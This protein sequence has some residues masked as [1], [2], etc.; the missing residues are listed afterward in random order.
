MHQKRR[1]SPPGGR[2]P[3]QAGR[4]NGRG[5]WLLVALVGVAVAGG[6]GAWPYLRRAA[7]PGTASPQALRP[8]PWPELSRLDPDDQAQFGDQRTT[9]EGLQQSDPPDPAALAAAFGRLGQLGLAYGFLDAAE[10]ALANASVLSPDDPRW[11]YYLGYLYLQR[12]RAAEA[13]SLLERTVAR[14]PYDVPAMVHLGE[15]F[16]DLKRVDD[17]KRVLNR[18]VQ[19]DPAAASARFVLG[20]IAFEEKDLAAAIRHWEAVLTLQPRATIVHRKLAEAYHRL[21]EEDRSRAHLA[22]RG[23][24]PVRLADPRIAEVTALRRAASALI[25]QGDGLMKSGHFQDAEAVFRRAVER[26]P[27]SVT[28]HLNHGAAL[29][30]LGRADG[31]TAE[32]EAA[33]RLDPTSVKAHQNLGA[34][35]WFAGRIEA[36]IREYEA[37]LHPAPDDAAIHFALAMLY[38][39]SGACDK[40]LAHFG[41]YLRRNPD[42]TKTLRRQVMCLADTGAYGKALSAAEAGLKAHPDDSVIGIVVVRLLAA[43]P[44]D[45]VRDGARAVK[46]A[47]GL[48]ARTR[49]IDAM[50]GLAMSYAEV[51]RLDDAIGLQQSAVEAHRNDPPESPARLTFL[52]AN[53]AAYRTGRPARRPFSE[54]EVRAKP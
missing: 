54:A 30:E 32:F 31:A 51:G 43:A 45:G 6:F 33:L 48:V 1:T 9:V 10:P 40:S 44:D 50:E 11:T 5:R 49:D 2:S 15:A 3:T 14:E 38:S 47:E 23:D 34:M 25:A 28:A 12:K 26:D 7:S 4:S 13:A 29:M 19:L 42:D 8:I 39:Q 21:G 36:A 20:E 16:R 53:L 35:A 18:A 22:Q 46:I 52:E 24:I 17:A 27:E 41:P 37:A